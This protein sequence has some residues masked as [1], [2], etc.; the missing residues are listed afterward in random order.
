LLV[1]KGVSKQRPDRLCRFLDVMPARCHTFFAAKRPVR[2]Q[3][4]SQYKNGQAN[5]AVWD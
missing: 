3:Q 5:L 2:K 1:E 4:Q